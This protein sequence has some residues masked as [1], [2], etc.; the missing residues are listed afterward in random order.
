MVNVWGGVSVLLSFA[1]VA[2]VRRA[3]GPLPPRSKLWLL[4]PAGLLALP[5]ASF[6][7]HYTHL[8]P[9]QSGHFAFRSVSR[10]FHLRVRKRG[11]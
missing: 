6:A 4:F 9:E 3:A 11:P 2:V 10:G 1:A 7:L 5:G 8:F